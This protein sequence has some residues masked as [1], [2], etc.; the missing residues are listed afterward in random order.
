MS[1]RIIG[2]IFVWLIA[3]AM[4]ILW[5]WVDAKTSIATY[6]ALFGAMAAL[7]I[8]IGLI[9]QLYKSYKTTWFWQSI[10]SLIFTA[11]I[12]IG[13]SYLILPKLPW[14]FS[15]RVAVWM[16]LIVGAIDTVVILIEHYWKYATNMNV[17]VMKI[18]KRRNAYAR[19]KDEFRTAASISSIRQSVLSV[20]TEDDYRML[21]D[22]A[23]L[24]S[25][26][27]KMICDRER[28][29][30]LQIPDY[31]YMTIVDLTL[32]NDMRGINKRFCLVNQKLPD[33]GRYVCCYRPQEY[34][35]QKMMEKYPWGIN[36]V[37]YTL[38]FW[39]KRVWPRLML[40]SRLYY[41]L[42]KGRKRMLSKTEVLGRLYYCGFEVDEIVPM[43]HIEYVFAHRHSQPY[44]QEQLKLYGP[45]IK[46]PRVCK[47]GE[48][49]YFYKMRTMHPYSEYIQK[50]VYDMYGTTDGDKAEHDFRITTWGHV[51]RKLWIDELPMILNLLKG[52]MKIVGVRP[53][54]KTKFDTYPEWL[55]ELRVQ[56]KPGLVP[57]FYA[58][59]PKTQ[60]EMFESEARYTRAYLKH[61]IITDWKYFWKAFYNIV[62]KHARSK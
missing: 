29:S 36:W 4:C 55:Q 60:E 8:V 1:K 54:S 14:H 16:I 39:T 26:Q 24:D 22:K 62:V 17:P 51:F 19:R 27:T 61:P 32:L 53:L 28:F 58:D 7:W 11:G 46:L 33:G 45:L 50:L 38:F 6:W 49:K 18:E 5:R 52:D 12:L 43:G 47:N 9:L 10:A 20:T 57:P 3:A 56:A 59:M 13:L 25:S 48:I 41:D 44:A 31:Q 40:T 30:L 21:L 23:R 35:K 42:T 34:I 15:P 37:V 2:D